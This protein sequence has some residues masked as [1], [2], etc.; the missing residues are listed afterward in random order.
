MLI[1]R[2]SA[3]HLTIVWRESIEQ[4]VSIPKLSHLNPWPPLTRCV[5]STVPKWARDIR[6]ADHICVCFFE[7]IFTRE[8]RQAQIQWYCFLASKSAYSSSFFERVET[9]ASLNPI[10]W[11][12]IQPLAA[13][14]NGAEIFKKFQLGCTCV[15][16]SYEVP[17]IST[18][19]VF[20]LSR[21]THCSIFYIENFQ[22]SQISSDVIIPPKL[23]QTLKPSF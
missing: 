18:P 5:L 15:A 23:K 1:F 10:I 19:K 9:S 21:A 20:K 17:Y 8:L 6:L 4:A 13:A 16:S 3:G 11:I 14:W 2:R 7:T 22:K 12:F